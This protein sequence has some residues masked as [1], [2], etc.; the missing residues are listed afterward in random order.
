LNDNRPKHISSNDK[1]KREPTATSGEPCAGHES[2]MSV[3]PRGTVVAKGLGVNPEAV[4]EELID[5]PV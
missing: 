5:V 2:T 1:N 3:S 4:M